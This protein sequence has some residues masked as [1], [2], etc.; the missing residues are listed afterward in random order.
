VA[1]RG[2]L[3]V[4]F[5][6]EHDSIVGL[7]DVA[8]RQGR[9]PVRLGLRGQGLLRDPTLCRRIRH[10]FPDPRMR[11]GCAPE[12]GKVWLTIKKISCKVTFGLKS[13][14]WE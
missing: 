4:Q 13:E 12:D 11:V 6:L 5:G 1:V 10:E 8:P 14:A 2:L 7:P 3:P 9:K